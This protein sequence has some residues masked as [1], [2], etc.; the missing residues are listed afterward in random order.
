MTTQVQKCSYAAIDNSG[1]R[2]TGVLEATNREEV[3][4]DLQNKEMIVTKIS[5]GVTTNPMDKEVMTKSIKILP[6]RITSEDLVIFTRELATMI[7]AGLP[8]VESL[9]TIAE[10]IENSKMQTIVRKMGSELI[11]GTSFSEALKAHPQVFDAMYIN[12]VKVGEIG[13]NL[14]VILLNLA[15]YLE[16][17]EELKNKVLSALYYPAAVITF[18]VLIV[19]GLFIFIIPRFAEIFSGFGSELP[20]LTRFFLDVSIFMQKFYLLIFA[21]LGV[22]IYMF[23]K[24]I[25]TPKGR[26]WFDKFKLTMPMVGSLVNKIVISRFARILSLL[27]SSGVPINQSLELVSAACGNAIMEEAILKANDN[28]MEGE[29]IAST[30]DKS[31]IF[32]VMVIHMMDVGER[33]GQLSEMLT[34]I[35]DF[36]DMQVNSAIRGLTSLI[37]PLLVISM[38][39]MIGF[40]ALSLFL[41]I[42][43]L[44]TLISA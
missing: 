6:E 5:C 10:D 23:S 18:A 9:Y 17:M 1:K 26:R 39:I 21:A 29:G 14:E 43:K 12:L 22:G 11:S 2:I 35:S 38:G 4:S 3:I 36:Y 44:P 7:N 32:P 28:V 8:L 37:E 27:Y 25:R 16:A 31:K 34:K 40:M 15:D 42:V 30:L 20:A 13:G 41:P 19:S 33:T 24:F